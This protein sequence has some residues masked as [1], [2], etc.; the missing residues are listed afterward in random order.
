MYAY[1]AV[2]FR[3]SNES[4]SVLLRTVADWIDSY[5]YIM[6][7]DVQFEYHESD[8]GGLDKWEVKITTDARRQSAGIT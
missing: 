6:V 8:G 5:P 3:E 7:E 2:V 4:L 1:G